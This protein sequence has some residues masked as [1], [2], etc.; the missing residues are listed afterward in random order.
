MTAT[1]RWIS[2]QAERASKDTKVMTE[3]SDLG[4]CIL[5][6]LA[7][8]G[9]QVDSRWTAG[10]QQVDSRWTAGGQQVDRCLLAAGGQQVHAA[11]TLKMLG[12]EPCLIREDN[13]EDLLMQ[14]IWY[15]C[16]SRYAWPAQPWHLNWG[17]DAKHAAIVAD[18]G[19]VIAAEVLCSLVH[20]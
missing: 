7:A 10:G 5:C 19:T 15:S 2:G 20:P 6:L 4:H 3:S 18:N 12:I 1:C 13:I 14:K 17:R 16:T 8:G 11:F 9:Q